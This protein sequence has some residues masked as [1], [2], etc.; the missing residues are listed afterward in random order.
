MNR[1]RKM[2]ELA[3]KPLEKYTFD[4]FENLWKRAKEYYRAKVQLIFVNINCNLKQLLKGK[5]LYINI[6]ERGYI[7]YERTRTEHYDVC[8]IRS[9]RKCIKN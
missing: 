8:S 6:K 2:E 3:D 1:F 7:G 5:I 4:E 9:N